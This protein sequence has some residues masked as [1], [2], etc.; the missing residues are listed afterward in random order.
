MEKRRESE[1]QAKSA[2]GI[3]YKYSFNILVA[4]NV[5]LKDEFKLSSRNLRHL[6]AARRR[7]PRSRQHPW[8]H[9]RG[10]SACLPVSALMSVLD[11]DTTHHG[12]T[13]LSAGLRPSPSLS[14][15]HGLGP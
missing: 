11:T 9:P 2:R 6:F 7:T 5:Q 4:L 10:L 8:H 3:K 15:S 13:A 14:V 12:T 1:S